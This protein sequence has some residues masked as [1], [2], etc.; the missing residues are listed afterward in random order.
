MKL[1]AIALAVVLTGC[2]TD[3]TKLPQPTAFH[4]TVSELPKDTPH[5]IKSKVTR[6]RTDEGKILSC[7]IELAQ[8]P[9]C[10]QHAM[11]QCVEGEYDR[12]AQATTVMPTNSC[13]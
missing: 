8:Y 13:G 5:A 4:V 3:S 2:A 9:I 7:Q 10:L 12:P 1:I 11:R 6:Q